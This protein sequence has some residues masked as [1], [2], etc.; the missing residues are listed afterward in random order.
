MPDAPSIRDANA[1]AA[2]AVELIGVAPPDADVTLLVNEKPSGVQKAGADG[3]W[4]FSLELPDKTAEQTLSVQVKDAKGMAFAVAE[5]VKVVPGEGGN[6]PKL[7]LL[8]QDGSERVLQS[9]VAQETGLIVER[10]ETAPGGKVLLAGRGDADM[11]VKALIG[12]QS[13]GEAK[14]DKLGQWR[15]EGPAKASG[16]L[17]IDLVDA[18]GKTKDRVD[19]PFTVAGASEQEL[20]AARDAEEAAKK[21]E[22]DKKAEDDKKAAE[23]S[24]AEEDKKAAEL[25]KA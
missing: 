6:P 3:K 13:I 24:K 14:V 23:A 9:G 1:T 4:T 20:A 10:A 11:I 7:T 21:A 18:G 2:G 19:L 12:G 5:R 22:Q 25:K 17:R 15:I 16:T 8:M